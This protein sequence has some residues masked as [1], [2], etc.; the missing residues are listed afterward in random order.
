MPE[1]S[2]CHKKSNSQ[3]YKKMPQ[4]HKRSKTTDFSILHNKLDLLL[5]HKDYVDNNNIFFQD[6]QEK[7]VDTN[8]IDELINDANKI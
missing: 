2:L 4:K 3:I 7:Y 8:K 6:L 1:N 5:K